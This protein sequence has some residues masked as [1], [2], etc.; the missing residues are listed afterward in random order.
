MV[1]TGIDKEKVML[2]LGRLEGYLKELK[3][4]GG[5]LEKS[6]EEDI[7]LLHAVERLL[8][9]A[10][11]ECLNIGSHIISGL[12]LERADTYREVFT[13]LKDT[14]ILPEK[15]GEAMEEFASFRN[16]LVHL[17]YR[18][19]EEEVVS[20]LDEI[21]HFERFTQQIIEYIEGT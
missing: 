3:S 1:P 14:G 11:E 6:K 8:Q 20:K 9:I 19:S 21:D 10:T 18:M 2:Q 16:R 15:L 7:V 13:R 12:G 4:V 17:Y 5:K